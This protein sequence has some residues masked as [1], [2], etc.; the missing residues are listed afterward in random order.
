MTFGSQSLT[1]GA[2]VK[3]FTY[4]GI[5]VRN[6]HFTEASLGWDGRNDKGE[7][8]ASSIYLVLVVTPEGESLLG[9]LPVI[10]R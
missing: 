4:T 2:S 7:L 5:L 1:P 9:K 10:R 6:L 3:I 8:V